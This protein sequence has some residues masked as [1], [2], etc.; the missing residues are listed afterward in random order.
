MIKDLARKL[1]TAHSNKAK[2]NRSK[3][4]KRTL[5]E[6]GSDSINIKPIRVQGR[7]LNR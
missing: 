3:M 1:Q 5:K 2:I 6:I 7:L 4:I